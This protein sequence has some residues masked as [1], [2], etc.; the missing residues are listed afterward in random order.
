MFGYKLFRATVCY[1]NPLRALREIYEQK[2][3]LDLFEQFSIAKSFGLLWRLGYGME[4]YWEICPE[5]MVLRNIGLEIQESTL[6][7]AASLL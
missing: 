4:M 3:V 1:C 7:N 6:E 5:N 2:D